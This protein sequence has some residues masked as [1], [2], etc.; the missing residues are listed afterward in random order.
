MAA[1]I[2]QPYSSQV[3]LLLKERPSVATM[4]WDLPQYPRRG[5]VYK[6]KGCRA[7]TAALAQFYGAGLLS[8]RVHAGTGRSVT[9]SDPAF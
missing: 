5:S 1:S 9:M 7:Q 4:Y 8:A 3:V 6:V 2:T